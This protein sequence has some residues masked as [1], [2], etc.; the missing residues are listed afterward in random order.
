[1]S[2]FGN[3]IDHVDRPQNSGTIEKE[4]PKR[5]KEIFDS[6]FAD[7]RGGDMRI[8]RDHPW[9]E[10]L[11]PLP[12][13]KDSPFP[14]K[15]HMELPTEIPW[16]FPSSGPDVLDNAKRI[17]DSLFKEDNASS[18]DF[19]A[20]EADTEK[21]YGFDENGTRELTP[22]E[23]QRLKEKLGWSDKKIDDNCRIDQDGTIHY[24]TDNQHLE[25]QVSACGVPYERR[26]IEYKGIKIEG[27]FPVF[28]SAFDTE[29][30]EEDYQSSN[31][32]Q[33]KEANKKLKEAL[34]KD[35]DLKD[36]FT[37]EQLEDIE[38]G[39][40]PRGYTW[41]HNEEPGKMQLVKTE[42]HDR[43]IGGAAHTG[44]NSIWGNKSVEK[45][46]GDAKKGESF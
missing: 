30:S 46:D 40:T 41:H 39:D 34:E 13:P 25:G 20:A 16:E 35:P 28:E 27:V 32:K 37:P 7:D 9:P 4:L 2:G 12:E 23:K 1:M 36:R 10:K 45:S 21:T 43:R 24:K 22:D 14:I 44:G 8:P 38:N 17:F 29:L 19:H 11:P 31:T 42:D 6:L 5:A 26:T 15:P 18:E 3:N 33:F